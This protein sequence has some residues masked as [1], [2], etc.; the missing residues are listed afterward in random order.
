VPD[1]TIRVG[2]RVVTVQVPG[3]F[4]VL[5]R[6]GALVDIENERGVRMTVAV[7]ALRRVDGTP[8]AAKDA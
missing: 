6:R 7:S 2:D 1:E 4:T 8:P 5:A 3:I